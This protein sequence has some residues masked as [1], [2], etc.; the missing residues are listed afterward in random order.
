LLFLAVLESML[1]LLGI[2]VPAGSGDWSAGAVARLV[3]GALVVGLIVACIEEMLFRGALL[4]GIRKHAGAA[5]ALIASSA[6]FAAVHF[7]KF[8]PMRAGV[9]LDWTAGPALLAQ[10][11]TRF[12]NPVII[13]SFLTLFAFGVLLGFMRLARGHIAQC[14]GFHAGVVAGLRIAGELCDS[15]PGSR[16]GFLVNRWDPER[17]WLAFGLLVALATVYALL[18]PRKQRP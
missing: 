17:G 5:T 7:V 3:L 10:G 15:A 2:R 14:I 18:C 9:D 8:K 13:D 1:L 4:S 16:F 6:V 11:L 12:S